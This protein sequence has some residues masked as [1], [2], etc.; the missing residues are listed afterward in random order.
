MGRTSRRQGALRAVHYAI[1]LL[2]FTAA[3][4]ESGEP[5]TTEEEEGPIRI[6]I[7]ISMTGELTD[8]A[9]DMLAAERLWAEQDNT[10]LGRPVELVI[11]DDESSPETAARLY[12]RL[13][14]QEKVDLLLGP[15]G[16]G[17]SAAVATVADRADRFILMPGASAS[18]VFT[19][20]E[21]AV[22]LLSPQ[23]M[24]PNLALELAASE[25]YKTV[26]TAA[27]DNPYGRDVVDGV[28]RFADE[29]GLE[30]VHKE[31][32][33]LEVSD[34]TSLIL[35]MK[36]NN[37]DVV[38]LGAEQSDGILF[39]RQAREQGLNPKMFILGPAA[40][41]V[42]DFVDSLGET[43]E[44]VFGTAQ[45]L[46]TAPWEGVPEFNELIRSEL[47]V[48]PNY[49]HAIGYGGLEILKMIAEDAGTLEDD[50]LMES[51][52]QEF[53]AFLGP[54]KI[55]EDGI[56]T[57]QR[58]VITQI[59]DGKIVAVYPEGEETEDYVLPTPTWDER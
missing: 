49:L 58:S 31:F 28:L 15:Y 3:C 22:Q 51:A 5:T 11:L 2:L 14:T 12:Q 26:A 10:I 13:I 41:T 43:S 18:T 6:G 7:S 45:W 53:E 16:S 25:G 54:W 57:A 44:Y 50:A 37:P 24:L 19:E 9:R 21:M 23:Q 39:M 29:H 56:Q 34:L 20:S 40:P 1:V 59:L 36:R 48:E 32:Y 42:Q 46:S 8:V 33:E 17:P 38:Y 55:D 47:D 4:R 35:S 27:V 30:V 52:Q